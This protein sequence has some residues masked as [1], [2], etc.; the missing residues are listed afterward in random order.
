MV[1]N[2]GV[3]VSDMK[4]PKLNWESQEEGV[5]GDLQNIQASRRNNLCVVSFQKDLSHLV[6]DSQGEV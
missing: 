5:W 4:G 1:E 6:P 3:K 2:Y